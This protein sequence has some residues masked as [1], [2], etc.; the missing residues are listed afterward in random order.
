MIALQ[1]IIEKLEIESVIGPKDKSIVA[2]KNL[3]S[4]SEFNEN[5]ICWLGDKLLT[6]ENVSLITN[7]T[8][9]CTN[10]VAELKISPDCTY[11]IT[12]NPR[13]G[14]LN[15]V[16]NF[17][18]KERE[19][20][21]SPRSFIDPTAK[22]GKDA[23]IDHFV[24]I[25]ENVQIGD[26]VSI[27]AGTVIKKN[28][29]IMNNVKMGSNCTIGGAGFGYEKNENG[30]YTFIPQIGNVVI[31]DNVEI[32]NNVCVD[33]AALGSTILLPNCKFDNL[34]QIA[35]GVVIGENTLITAN[36]MIA[37]S[38]TVGKNVWVAPSAS[39][40]NSITVGD[41]AF[42]GMSASV[43]KNVKENDVVVGNPGRVLDRK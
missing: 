10:A 12:K 24:L 23:F 6:Q 42:I 17:F 38:T 40:L 30:D 5:T 2:V 36:V 3:A 1:D 20:S 32:G 34:I 27:E 22:I 13:R 19:P 35:H 4:I 43:L 15:L 26:N 31:H 41:N 37:G 16:R 29:I 7:A 33:R 8:L 28:T 21:I 18:H 11:L 9:I 25:E 14:F 39:L